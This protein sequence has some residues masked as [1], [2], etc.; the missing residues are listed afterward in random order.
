[1]STQV[2]CPFF[3]WAIWFNC[4]QV[5]GVLYIFWLLTPYQRYDCKVFFPFPSLPFKFDIAP[6][7]YFCSFCCLYFGVISKKSLPNS[8]SWNFSPVFSSLSFIVLGLIFRY[9]IYLEFIFV[10]DV[11]Y[12]SNFIL[13][14][15]DIQFFQHHLLKRLLSPLC[16][17]GTLAEDHLVIHEDLSLGFLYYYIDLRACLY[18]SIILFWVLKLCNMFGNQEVLQFCSFF[19]FPKLFLL[20]EVPWDS[21]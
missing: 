18:G 2:L 12:R 1:M 11:R 17:L 16:S 10:Y 9:L 15:V 4:C 21:L 6:F 5:V 13:L 8:M 7:V 14:R 20:F 3:N 19:F